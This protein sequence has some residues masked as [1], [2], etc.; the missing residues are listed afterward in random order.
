MV[1]QYAQDA[2]ERD[3][4]ISGLINLYEKEIKKLN[5]WTLDVL[6]D[7]QKKLLQEEILY[8]TSHAEEK[9]RSGDI[10]SRHGLITG[11]LLNGFVAKIILKT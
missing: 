3:Q 8:L 4:Y 9:F 10:A 11:D 2:R 5:D 7:K 6:N 1:A